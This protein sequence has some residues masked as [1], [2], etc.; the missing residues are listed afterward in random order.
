VSLFAVIRQRWESFATRTGLRF[1]PPVPTVILAVAAGVLV[2]FVVTVDALPTQLAPSVARDRL[3]RFRAQFP[4]LPDSGPSGLICSHRPAFFWPEHTGADSYSLRVYSS[5]GVEQVTADGLKTTFHLIQPPGGLTPGVSY[6]FEV[7]AVVAGEPI[8]WQEH[9]FTVRPPPDDLEPLLAGSRMHLDPEEGAFVLLGY[10]A[11][12][13]SPS[14]CDV[15]SA[16]LQWKAARGE[17]A[18]LPAGTPAIWLS[19]VASR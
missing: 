3:A 18:G 13:E 6:R 9:D 12:L 16:F 19:S 17:L 10:Y 14:P 5:D 4:D 15:I 11:G 7:S 1:L 2:P 8:P